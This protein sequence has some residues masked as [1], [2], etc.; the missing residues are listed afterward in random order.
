MRKYIISA[1]LG[2][3]LL[4]CLI[5]GGYRIYIEAKDWTADAKF[6]ALAQAEPDQLVMDLN[7]ESLVKL[8]TAIEAEQKFRKGK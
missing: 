5:V 1:I 3:I 2:W 8:K 4:N 6:T 7:S